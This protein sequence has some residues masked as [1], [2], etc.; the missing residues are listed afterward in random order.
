M[1][2]KIT[3]NSSFHH[4]SNL[5]Y[6][7]NSNKWLVVSPD[8]G[9]H[10]VLSAIEKSFLEALP[11]LKLSNLTA[12]E[13]KLLLKLFRA[14]VIAIDGIVYSTNSSKSKDMQH[15]TPRAVNDK[16][17]ILCIFHMHNFCNLNCSY[18]YTIE[19]G[20]NKK[21]ISEEVI[22]SSIDQMLLLPNNMANFEFHGGEPT[23]AFP[24]IEYAVNYAKQRYYDNKKF[25][26]FSIQTNAYSLSKD[27]INFFKENNF[28]I[29]VSLDGTQ[30][31][32]DHYRI[33]RQ[34]QG[35]YIKVVEGI[36][37][38]LDAGLKCDAVCVVHRGNIDKMI[39]MYESMANLGVSG[40]R[41]L[42]VFKSGKATLDNWIDGNTYFDKY[43]EL[44]KHIDNFSNNN[45][46]KLPNLIAGEINSITS[47]KREYMCMRSPCGAGV[48]M[49]S[50]D[51]NG[52]MY[53]CEEMTGNI[54]FKIG[55]V[56][57]DD[58][59][60][61]LDTH[62]MMTTLKSRH[63]DNIPLCSKCEWRQLCHG[64]CVHKSYTHFGKLDKQSEFCDYYK[65]IYPAL[66]WL[67]EERNIFSNPVFQGSK[68]NGCIK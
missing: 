42:P 60:Q 23:M 26:N 57:V 47:F 39:E 11:N 6:E 65:K 29:R 46:C 13:Q 7:N 49:I 16:Y 21:R 14:G 58:L 34:G 50:I 37:K 24:L 36:R 54:F 53:P 44:I 38:I 1:Q 52:D 61:Q 9:G 10:L 22:K 43:F 48:S 33:N 63:V 19:E 62:P 8:T 67:N 17:P 18:C 68:G 30:E 15:I 20:V 41:F 55:N 25:V 59:K 31:T 5:Y 64:G 51:I 4:A 28:G 32:H 56:L 40:I 3:E 2:L 66:I 35:S 45:S 27:I 12:E